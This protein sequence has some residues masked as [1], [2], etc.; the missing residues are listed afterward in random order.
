MTGKNDHHLREFP[1]KKLINV[2][3]LKSM[4]PNEEEK[5]KNL[6]EQLDKGE[7][8]YK[9]DLKIGCEYERD[10][11]KMFKMQV[12]IKNQD[13]KRLELKFQ[14]RFLCYFFINFVDKIMAMHF[15][16]NFWEDIYIYQE[17]K[18]VQTK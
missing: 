9:N 7:D 8:D 14:V 4:P 16:K 15:F 5:K 13:F 12:E 18:G 3:F 10:F 2:T 11:M 6:L 17:F 1:I